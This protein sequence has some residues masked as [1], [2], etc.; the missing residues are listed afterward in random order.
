[1]VAPGPRVTLFDSTGLAIQHRAV[2]SA[3]LEACG[4]R[5]RVAAETVRL[6][7]PGRT[8]AILPQHSVTDDRG[9][10]HDR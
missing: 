6:D 3:A 7:R 9:A 5:G 2:A 10:S 4:M 1:M 8:A